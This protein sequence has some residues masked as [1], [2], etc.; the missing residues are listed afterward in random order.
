MLFSGTS[1][2]LLQIVKLHLSSS[3]DFSPPVIS[4]QRFSFLCAS[5]WLSSPLFS[6]LSSPLNAF[7]LVLA[8]L[9]S[10]PPVHFLL[11]P[12]DVT[13]S[14]SCK[15]S[16]SGQLNCLSIRSWLSTFDFVIIL[17]SCAIIQSYW[18]VGCYLWVQR[19]STLGRQHFF[20]ARM[21]TWAWA[22]QLR[23]PRW[24]T[25]QPDHVY[26]GLEQTCHFNMPTW[27]WAKQLHAPPWIPDS[28]ITFMQV[29]N[30][31]AT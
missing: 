5:S 19:S 14:H 4:F 22:E 11:R 13:Q 30:K 21:P 26:A 17:V 7:E 6:S 2:L 28:Q 24:N 27:A 8:N 16:C 3:N 29:W 1:D 15:L 25:W 23:A 12:V 20:Q 10:V 9:T 31:H 18:T